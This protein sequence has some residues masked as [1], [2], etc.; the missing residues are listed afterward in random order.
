MKNLT[1]TCFVC[2]AGPLTDLWAN[3]DYL[4]EIK[5]QDVT[6]VRGYGDSYGPQSE[7]R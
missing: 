7:W 2:S 1:F 3:S 4:Y 6:A 5:P